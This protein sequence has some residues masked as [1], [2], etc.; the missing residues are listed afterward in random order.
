MQNLKKSYI[1]LSIMLAW[2][3]L[4]LVFV[5]TPLLSNTFVR[6]ILGIPV[7]LFIPGY[8]LTAALFPGK[9][10]LETIERI[11][12]S[13]GLSIAVVPLLGLLLNFTFG[14]RLLQ[15]LLTLCLYIIALIIIAVYRRGKLPDE[16]QFRVDLD[17]VHEIIDSE[18]NASKSRTDRILTG[19]LIFSIV[20]AIGT[21]FFVITTPRVGEKF[22][23]FYILGSEGKAEN[24]PTELRYKVPAAIRVGVV[25]HEY[26]IVNYTV[27]I[28]LDTETLTDTWFS[29][30]HNETW[31]GNMTFVP[32]KEGT[33]M[34]LALWLFKDD[35]FTA[36]YRELHLWVNV[37]R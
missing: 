6:T 10:D 25:N 2:T 4:T 14:I 21:I 1:D 35:N 31:E 5:L 17:Y 33:D 11:A 32:N 27:R 12:L 29:L 30:P 13:F 3:I 8:V 36:P 37:T 19:V 9:D 18:F 22:T 23:E 24:Y 26:A 28:A 16:E 34:K 20:L 7:V 15:V